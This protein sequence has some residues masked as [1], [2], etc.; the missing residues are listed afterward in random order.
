MTVYRFRTSDG[1]VHR[2]QAA[3]PEAAQA[4]VKAN[5]LPVTA[6]PSGPKGASQDQSRSPAD[7]AVYLKELAKQ[8]AAGAAHPQ[9]I[10]GPLGALNSVGAAVFGGPGAEMVGN[11]R[12]A[13]N[14]AADLFRMATG[15][16]IVPSAPIHDAARDAA[17][18]QM[19]QAQ[20]ANPIPF[21]GG[22]IGS[23]LAGPQ[24]GGAGLLTGLGMDALK[25]GGKVAM[26]AP[27][28]A[29]LADTVGTGAAGVA[30][31]LKALVRPGI[32]DWAKGT[33]KATVG[34]GAT[35]ALLGAQEGATPEEHLQNA[36]HSGEGGAV[37]SGLLH[38]VG[39]PIVSKAAGMVSDAGRALAAKVMPEGAALGSATQAKEKARQM[40]ANLADRA[41]VTADNVGDRTAAY[42]PHG[43]VAGEALG[44]S[45]V[46]AMG[47]TAR[48]S[49]TTG[50]AVR[51]FVWNRAKAAPN[52]M[53]RDVT[54]KLGVDPEAA[55]GN[56]DS[57]VEAGRKRANE[58]FTRADEAYAEGVDSS[59]LEELLNRPFGQS[60]QKSIREGAKNTARTVETPGFADVE[61]N[62]PG[63]SVGPGAGMTGAASEQAP[64]A[65]AP[66]QPPAG[67]APSKAPSQ[68][69]S[70]TQFVA[71]NK[72]LNDF[73]Y[74]SPLPEAR[75]WY[76]R[77]YPKVYQPETGIA[78]EHMA[79][80][81]HDAHYFP[82]LETPPDPNTFHEALANDASAYLPHSVNQKVYPRPPGGLFGGSAESA[83]ANARFQGREAADEGFARGGGEPP[84]PEEGD[85][86]AMPPPEYESARTVLPTGEF[87]N[88]VRQR[89]NELVDWNNGRPSGQEKLSAKAASKNKERAEWLKQFTETMAGPTGSVGEGELPLYRP[90]LEE[91]RDYLGVKGAQDKVAGLLTGKARDFKKA[92]DNLRPGGD[93]L[94]GHAQIANEL[95]D[96]W[97]NG[98]LKAGKFANPNVRI[99]LQ[100]AFGDASQDFINAAER[101]AELAATGRRMAPQT[102]SGTMPLMAAD[103]ETEAG[104]PGA[105]EGVISKLAS[106]N[107]MGAASTA[108]GKGL[109]Y[110]GTAGQHPAYRDEL[111]RLLMLPSDDPEFLAIL[112]NAGVTPMGQDF[113]APASVIGGVGGA[114]QNRNQNDQRR[115]LGTAR[116]PS[117][118][119]PLSKPI[120]APT[121]LYGLILIGS[122]GEGL[123]SYDPIDKDR[124]RRS[125][126]RVV[127]TRGLRPKA[128]L[129]TELDGG[130]TMASLYAWTVLEDDGREGPDR[131][132]AAGYLAW[133][134]AS[135]FW[136][137]A[138]GAAAQALCGGARLKHGETGPVDSLQGSRNPGMGR[139]R[140]SASN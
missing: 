100:Q 98:Q 43:Q 63:S 133:H 12:G 53:L 115:A 113:V 50:D 48:R 92:W 11:I 126:W 132:H 15:R 39:A 138:S 110:V 85:Y 47:A 52:A 83:A 68:G 78:D 41:G 135:G 117:R 82:D 59:K 96:M 19:A 137:P 4:F 121:G 123:K 54:D 30:A 106:G 131:G 80:L 58:A 124:T 67:R 35:G 33:A 91:S 136:P 139:G 55:Q 49:G 25:A 76:G 112:K 37:A 66:E 102:G 5:P 44:N 16:P 130:A 134:D 111:G 57:I 108:V 46:N 62:R 127:I 128:A 17:A 104:G 119:A 90:A 7:Q 116:G 61:V 64:G 21:A 45:G 79:E 24:G 103:A 6:P 75:N 56:V 105:M 60:I 22:Q 10:S 120:R 86:G 129:P 99:N 89:G 40:V 93:I 122:P 114:A 34:G 94:A 14:D 3:S 88:Q 140:K 70:L 13:G 73:G 74:M 84:P 69:L 23:L 32:L 36:V 42:I 28:V 72:G 8:R 1:V 18:E 2:V 9:P 38:G 81:A 71:K 20:K 101:R 51:D 95:M 107:W 109:Q 125:A 77:G 31:K 26:K 87:Y 118:P 97:G 29:A 65:W 27:A